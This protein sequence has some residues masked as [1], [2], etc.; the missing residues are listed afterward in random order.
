MMVPW[1]LK[2]KRSKTKTKLHIIMV[3]VHISSDKWFQNE[4][5]RLNFN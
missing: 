5:L 4:N 1:V 3:F 2:S